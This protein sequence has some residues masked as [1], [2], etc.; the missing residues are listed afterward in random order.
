M[1]KFVDY[2]KDCTIDFIALHY[3]GDFEGLA[4]HIGEYVAT[5][6]KTVWLTEWAFPNVTLPVTQ[7]FYNQSIEFLDRNP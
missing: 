2:C 3:Y 7:T 1:K 6:N 4:S 5:F